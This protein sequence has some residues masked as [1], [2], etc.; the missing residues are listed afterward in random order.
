MKNKKAGFGRLVRGISPQRLL[1]DLS[2]AASLERYGPKIFERIIWRVETDEPKIAL[3][4]DDGPHETSTPRLLETLEKHRVKATFFLVGKNVERHFPVAQQIVRAGHEIGNHTFSH[5]PLSFLSTRKIREEV[6]RA[7]V[8]LCQLNGS[9]PKYMRPP[10]GF[11][12]P[13]VLDI[14]EQMGYRL[15]IGDV[16]PR[17]S[18]RPGRKRIVQRVLK[19]TRAG[20]II[21]LHDG[22]N[23]RRLD[24]SQTLGAVE[25]IIP[26]LTDLGFRF[27]LISALTAAEGSRNGS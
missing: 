9:K 15:V 20:S 25:D 10:S 23:A 6:A 18:H 8:A 4:F 27:V 21:I 17:D 22:G 14:V 19:R 13:R 24:R 16:Y 7:E 12:T 1:G 26:R 2:H 5:I 3:T 11:F